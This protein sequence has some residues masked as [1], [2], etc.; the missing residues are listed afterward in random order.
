MEIQNASVQR[1][2]AMPSSLIRRPD[3]WQREFSFRGKQLFYNRIPFNNCAERAVEVPIAFDFLASQQQKESMLEVGNVLQHYENALSDAFGIR[4]R[5]IIDKFEE[6]H[7]IDNIDIIDVGQEEKYQ[8]I[9]SI[10][11]MEHVGQHCAPSG[12]FGEQNR[13]NDLEAPLKAIAKLYDL[14]AVGGRALLTVPFGVLTDGGWYIQFSAEYLDLLGTKYGIPQEALSVG[15]LKCIAKESKWSNPH[16]LWVEATAEEVRDVRYD[17]IWSGARAIAVI[18]MVKLAQP[19]VFNVAGSPT[20]LLYERSQL[21][22][23]LFFTMGLLRSWF[24]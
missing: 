18:E 6:G 21:A 9:V 24:Q 16:Q 15:F 2:T 17:A 23:N 5:R 3:T 7:G 12:Q 20:S 22:K 14:L 8:A 4:C 11:T 10:S 1:T 19:F 13:V